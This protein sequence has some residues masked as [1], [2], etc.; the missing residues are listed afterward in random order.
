M[1][2]LEH[3]F[4]DLQT[5]YNKATADLK[6]KEDDARELEKV[7]KALEQQKKCA[8]HETLARV[9]LENKLQTLKV[10]NKYSCMHTAS[11]LVVL[12]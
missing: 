1:N 4:A 3:R 2:V 12:S 11:D 10:N 6:S 7:K 8:E 9:E 5:K